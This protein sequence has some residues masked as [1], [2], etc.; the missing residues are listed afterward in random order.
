MSYMKELAEDLNEQTDLVDVFLQKYESTEY[1][2]SRDLVIEGTK[3]SNVL[4]A[5]LVGHFGEV[6]IG[7]FKKEDLPV[8][9]ESRE[10]YFQKLNKKQ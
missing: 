1:I 7:Y 8:L 4:A 3:E 5:M 2:T 9:L 6:M 10:R